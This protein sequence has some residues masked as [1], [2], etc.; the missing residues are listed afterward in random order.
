MMRMKRRINFFFKE[1]KYIYI[2]I[3]VYIYNMLSK[4]T[5]NYKVKLS[6]LFTKKKL[7]N[8]TEKNTES[9][10]PRKRKNKLY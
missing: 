6:K 5:T 3:Y 4:S 1:N 7:T 9:F 10:M 2:Y 8:K